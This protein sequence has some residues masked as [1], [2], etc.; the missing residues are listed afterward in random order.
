MN[1]YKDLIDGINPTINSETLADA[2]VAKIQ[3]I[4]R[5]KFRK[6]CAL[7]ITTSILMGFTI[8]AGAVSGWDYPAVARYLFGG[9]QIVAD[10]MHD[11][12]NY[13]IV[14]NTIEGIT[15]KITG[16][17]VDDMTIMLSIEASSE[18]PIFDENYSFSLLPDMDKILFDHSLDEW[19]SC[20]W[21]QSSTYNSDLYKRTLQYRLFYIEEPIL[22]GN[23]YSIVFPRAQSYAGPD[24][25]ENRY[26]QG[27]VEIKFT[28]DKLA[29]MNS[30][31]VNPDV[32]LD[33][34]NT[35]DEI[36]INPF[37]I[38]ISANGQTVFNNDVHDYL[39]L[40]DMGGKEIKLNDTQRIFDQDGQ[41][42]F[43]K[44]EDG[45]IIVRSLA[46]FDSVYTG[47]LYDESGN[48]VILFYNGVFGGSEGSSKQLK[49]DI[50][51]YSVIDVNNLSAII[52]DGV[53]IP[54]K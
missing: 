30:I 1:N 14:E 44:T 38:F 24:Y 37:N 7:I 15:F 12:I 39:S 41:G 32:L 9:S 53:K 23:E 11:E 54:L 5:K 48:E 43:F 16:L 33:N 45:I 13:T 40:V 26:L 3:I 52:V 36:R 4:R 34:G 18:E 49:V 46:D 42:L 28:V 27:R 22:E 47:P 19:I 6:T 20:W 8:T 21:Q 35:I 50:Y 17:Y 25:P 31:T 29:L 2:V 51:A 10:G